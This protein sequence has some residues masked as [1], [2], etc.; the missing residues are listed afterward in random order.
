MYLLQISQMLHVR[1]GLSE[2]F[3]NL[4]KSHIFLHYAVIFIKLLQSW[5][6]HEY[7]RVASIQTGLKGFCFKRLPCRLIRQVKAVI[8]RITR[9]RS[10]DVNTIS[11]SIWE[12]CW[13]PLVAEGVMNMAA[14][15]LLLQNLFSV[16]R[17][18]FCRRG[19]FNRQQLFKYPKIILCIGVSFIFLNSFLAA[20]AKLMFLFHLP[21]Q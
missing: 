19:L 15:E 2:S 14:V 16:D 1:Q 11:N 18:T 10:T 7:I 17:L 12:S 3:T 4:Y 13:E 20:N 21:E 9:D 5:L 8:I 6:F